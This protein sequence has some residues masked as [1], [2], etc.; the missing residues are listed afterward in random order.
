M[1]RVLEFESFRAGAP[2]FLRDRRDGPLGPGLV[3][4]RQSAIGVNFVDIYQRNGLYP[5]GPVPG[6]EAAGIVEAVA[7][8]VEGFAPGTRVAYAGPPAGSYAELRDLPAGRLVAVPDGVDERQLAGSF[9]RGLTA[10]LLLDRVLPDVGG[11]PVLVHAA[12]GGLGLIL[13]QWLKRR[14]AT[15]IGTVGSPAKA[16]LARARGLDH[17][18]LYRDDDFRERVREITGGAGVVA[19][20][21]GIGGETLLRSLEALAPFGTAASLGQVSGGLPA[22]DPALLVNRFLVRPS[23]LAFLADE[24]RFRPA[25]EAWFAALRDGICIEGGH[26]YPFMEAARA[27]DD[28]EAGRTSGPVRL[29]VEG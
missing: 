9:L 21:D 17:A 5:L 28:M 20:I 14:G 2:L 4:V 15:V 8:D 10:G 29:L 19:A 7:P 13:V 25:A 24:T 16:E 11:K 18:I 26:S 3:R 12:A 23:I 27:L 22:I 6:V 1:A